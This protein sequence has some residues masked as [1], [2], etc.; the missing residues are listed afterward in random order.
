MLKILFLVRSYQNLE[1]FFAFM[2]QITVLLIILK[3][4]LDLVHILTRVH[5]LPSFLSYP[6]WNNEFYLA[7]PIL[8]QFRHV[9]LTLVILPGYLY[10]GQASKKDQ[11]HS[12]SFQERW[13]EMKYNTWKQCFHILI[14]AN[15]RWCCTFKLKANCGSPQH[16]HENKNTV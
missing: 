7:K 13:A 12:M 16:V 9:I 10:T 8:A 1:M 5:S 15:S 11:L 4:K 6:N 14:Y 3:I 2:R